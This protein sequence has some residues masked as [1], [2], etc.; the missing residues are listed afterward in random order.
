V[1]EKVT[2]GGWYIKMAQTKKYGCS[3][4]PR[5]R[6]RQI[7]DSQVEYTDNKDIPEQQKK[8]GR[9]GSELGR[10]AMAENRDEIYQNVE[11]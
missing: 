2:L 10:K 8:K 1:E 6:N 9:K 4:H 5:Q 11:I 3:A 7:I